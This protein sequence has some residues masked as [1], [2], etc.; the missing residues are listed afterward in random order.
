M[1]NINKIQGKII[2]DSVE[3]HI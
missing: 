1:V 2:P 3:W